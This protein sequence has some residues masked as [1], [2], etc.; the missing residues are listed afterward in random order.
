MSR[1]RYKINSEEKTSRPKISVEC[2]DEYNY[3]ATTNSV[4]K[5]PPAYI[6]F[7]IEP[8]TILVE[9]KEEKNKK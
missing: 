2:A 5:C 7:G 9:L 8:E 3:N 4:T 1:I 6:L